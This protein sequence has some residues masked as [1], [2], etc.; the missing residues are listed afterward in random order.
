M[1]TLLCMVPISP[2]VPTHSAGA[3]LRPIGL[4]GVELTSG[5]W[6]GRMRTN[7]EVTIPHGAR[8]LESAGNL[9]NLRAAAS[10]A[11]EY[12]GAA[13]DAGVTLPFLDSDVYKWL[14]AVG[15]ELGSRRDPALSVLAD[16]TIEVVGAAQRPDGYL[17]SYVQLTAPALRFHDFEWGHELYCV[18][19]LIQAAVAWKRAVDDDRLLTI[20][21]R[22]V[23][24]V[25]DVLGSGRREAIDGHP[26]IETALVE[27]F[28]VTGSE[29]HLDLARTLIERRGRGL[30]RPDRFG[31]AYWQ[32]HVG[33][34][35]APEPVGHAVRQL[36]LDCGAVDVA[37]ETDDREL[38]DAVVRRWDVMVASRTYLTGGLG[39]RQRDEAF[40][41]AYELPPDVAYAETCA[42]IASVMLAW[43]LLLAS[44]EARFAD[45]IERTS[46]N[47]VLAGLGLDGSHF[48]YANPLHV[49]SGEGDA[50][51]GPTSTR[52]R[53]WFACACCPPNLMRFLATVPDRVATVDD[54]GL[55]LH[56]F[57]T[58]SIEADA[59]FGHLKV[60]V[61]TEYP[62]RGAIG[63]T[64]D[65]APHSDA[66]TI[67]ARVPSW[68][69]GGLMRLNGEAATPIETGVD[70]LSL[71]RRWH[72]G[73]RFR[74]ELDMPIRV[75]V[76]DSRIDAVRGTIAIERG[77]L[78]YAVEEVDLPVGT[79]LDS[80]SFDPSVSP[81][82]ASPEPHLG[83]A[84]LIE[85]GARTHASNRPDWPYGDASAHAEPA[86]GPPFRVR[87]V[88]YF[89]WGNRGP[90]GMRVWLPIE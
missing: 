18:G 87:A 10:G 15:W 26:L 61:D 38:L 2:V 34:R 13:D 5:L 55:Q 74:I 36:Y 22:A 66:W 73:D 62:W 82:L 65:E 77:P 46:L 59:P 44:G 71:T 47:A 4:G 31:S 51:R 8:Q 85:L 40:G 53:S 48:L 42:A 69:R 45:L 1:P 23:A 79:G 19:H 68:C 3:R 89:A 41:D 75:T 30:L 43:R 16:R 39:S 72:P 20:A 78:V 57:A 6:A 29:R 58:G 24:S 64:I 50:S 84:T 11:G 27:L 86:A 83:D 63:L 90:G 9:A 60:R 67:T 17:N 7:R 35:T 88:P 21:E 56:Q 28:R 70:R 37:V 81:R 49:R 52:R 32:D 12:A 33:V 54:G 80:I 25:A 14:E 76:P